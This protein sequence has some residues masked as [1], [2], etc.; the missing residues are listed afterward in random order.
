MDNDCGQLF[1]VGIPGPTVEATAR[2][3]IADLGVGGIIL[4][5][6]NIEDPLQVAELCR[7]LQLLAMARQGAPLLLAVDQE[8]GPV[9]RLREPFANF[10]AARSWGEQ[11]DAGALE[12]A[13][14]QMAREMCLVG[15]NMNL[16]PVLDV[17]RRAS[18]PLWERS[19]GPEPLKVARLGMA[20]LRGFRSGG[21]IPVAKHF[22]G[23]GTT[24]F[25]SHLVLP[26]A[27]PGED[28]RE[29]DLF[30]FRMAIAAGVPAIMS[31]HVVVP[32]WDSQPATL[33]RPILGGQLRTKLGFTGMI[34]SD[35]LEMGAI[36][37]NLPVADAAAQAVAAGV[38]MLLICEHPDVVQEAY[39]RIRKQDDLQVQVADSVARVRRLKATLKS[40]NIDFPAVKGYFQG[41]S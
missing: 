8:G 27:Q 9:R 2:H 35:D 16:A 22:P 18:C 41:K 12:R 40:V 28:Y 10:P 11:D 38:N 14:A 4:F 5:A 23:L 39:E 32:E 6:R 30:P 21:V 20:A 15:L 1:M 26:A 3:F 29:E 13:A 19:Y 37:G 31:A 7:E 25:D 34:L 17:A 36:A 33:S 24:I